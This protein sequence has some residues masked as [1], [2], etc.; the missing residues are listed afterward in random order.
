MRRNNWGCNIIWHCTLHSFFLTSFESFFCLTVLSTAMVVS[1]YLRLDVL[2]IFIG[3]N[4]SVCLCVCVFRVLSL[5]TVA[6][7]L[8]VR[9]TL[10]RHCWTTI[11]HGLP[12][13]LPPP[14]P[15]HSRFHCRSLA[16]IW[17]V[18]CIHVLCTLV[19]SFSLL[20]LHYLYTR[21]SVLEKCSD[22]RTR[23]LKFV[24]QS[25]FDI[26]C[27]FTLHP[28][29]HQFG[30]FCGKCWLLFLL[31]RKVNCNRVALPQLFF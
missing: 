17:S 30:F 20:R 25:G 4:W 23:W 10:M 22:G 8:H 18:F 6:W 24:I 19:S 14:H 28:T 7:V 15:S 11:L 12:W 2:S 13:S 26:F 27:Q 1:F 3:L 16:R 31:L 5:C 29:L 21:F 9:R